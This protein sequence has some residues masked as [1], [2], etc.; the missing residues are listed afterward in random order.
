MGALIGYELA[1]RLT[2][3]GRA[4]VHFFPTGSAAPDVDP[5]LKGAADKTE[6]ELIDAVRPLG[7]IPEVV[8]A[9]PDLRAMVLRALRADLVSWEH[10]VEEP[11]PPL[12]CPI[13]AMAGEQDPVV[14][15]A[16]VEGWRSRTTGPFELKRFAGAHLFLESHVAE[17]GQIVRAGC[18]LH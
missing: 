4:P 9:D 15:V 6:F 12:S 16:S 11:A 10:Y 18:G 7:G 5:W 1:R 17:I 13:T 8:V 2:A 14:E 3:A